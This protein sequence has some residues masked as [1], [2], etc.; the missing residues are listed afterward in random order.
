MSE[1]DEINC[2]VAAA[3]PTHWLDVMLRHSNERHTGGFF[4]KKEIIL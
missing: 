3:A 1:E 4:F 2:F